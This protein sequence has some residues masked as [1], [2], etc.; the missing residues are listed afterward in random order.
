MKIAINTRLLLKDKLEGIGWFTY[1]TLKRIVRDHPEHDF[2]FL[3]D[4]PFDPSFIFAANVHP[5]VV[6]PPTRHPILQYWWFEHALPKI[7]KSIQPDLFYSPDAYNSLKSPFK[8][9]MVIHD[10]NF[11][12]YPEFLP[13]VDRIYL[14]HF[15]PLFARKA[16]R[17]LTVSQFSKNDIHQQYGI[18]PEKIDVVYNGVNELYSRITESEKVAIRNK[19]SK[20][21]A[22]FI[23]IG[24][25]NPRKNIVR[26]FQAF[27]LYKQ[28][29]ANPVKLMIV[30]EKMYW[31]RAIRQAYEQMKHQSDVIFTGYLAPE[32]LKD[33]TS[34]A[35]ALTYVPVFEGFGIPIIEAFHAE[36]P[37]ITSNVTSMPE[38]AG[39]AAIL[40][41][42][43]RVEAIAEAMKSITFDPELRLRLVKAGRQ[44]RQKFHWEQTATLCWEAIE[45]TIATQ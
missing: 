26:L 5:V 20:G 22:Y 30:G 28:S 9:L 19:M 2:Y 3:F 45:K 15:S 34:A 4:R 14:Q 33:I 39:E 35:L 13:W 42:P 1:E 11:E 21:Q 40:V 37:V 16:N 32:K 38:V 43:F 36:T 10:L 27:D 23:F 8:S 12:H 29:I 24:A 6:S 41:D 18:E 31:N 17:I 7:L 44:Q 25:L